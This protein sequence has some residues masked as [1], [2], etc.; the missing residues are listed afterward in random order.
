MSLRAKVRIIVFIVILVPY[1]RAFV[2]IHPRDLSHGR[3]Y[4]AHALLCATG[5]PDNGFW[6]AH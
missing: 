4:Q 2:V 6:A 3:A 1:G 5:S